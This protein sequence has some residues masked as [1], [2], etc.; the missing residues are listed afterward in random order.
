[1]AIPNQGSEPSEPIELHD[2]AIVNEYHIDM[3]VSIHVRGPG[4]VAAIVTAAKHVPL[5]ADAVIS[6][7]VVQQVE[8]TDDDDDSGEGC[9]I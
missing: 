7:I 6:R 2:P 3:T 1:M 4:P 9:S 5:P 8:R